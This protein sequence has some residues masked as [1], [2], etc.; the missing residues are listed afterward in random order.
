MA[1]PTS[2][3]RVR[4]FTSDRVSRSSAR[5]WGPGTQRSRQAHGQCRDGRQLET[6]NGP[7]RTQAPQRLK[8]ADYVAGNEDARPSRLLRSRSTPIPPSWPLGATHDAFAEVAH[9]LS[10]DSTA[11]RLALVSARVEGGGSAS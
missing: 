7:E 3:G 4:G 9:L 5:S 6:P 2:V 1:N 8:E 10:R 11:E